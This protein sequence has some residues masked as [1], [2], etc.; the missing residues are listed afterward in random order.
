MLAFLGWRRRCLLLLLLLLLLLPAAVPLISLT[1]LPILPSPSP[2]FV[3]VPTSATTSSATASSS[4]SPTATSAAVHWTTVIGIVPPA[5]TLMRR[6]GVRSAVLPAGDHP[7]GDLGHPVRSRLVRCPGHHHLGRISAHLLRHVSGERCRTI[8]VGSPGELLWVLGLLW[9]WRRLLLLRTTLGLA[10]LGV[11]A[12]LLR[13]LA[14]VVLLVGIGSRWL[15]ALGW[16]RCRSLLRRGRTTVLLLLGRRR[17]RRSARTGHLH[18]LRHLSRMLLHRAAVG[19]GGSGVPAHG[20]GVLWVGQG[21]S[22]K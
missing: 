18:V 11:A 21:S 4:T 20:H 19:H 15:L 14:V 10:V 3:V 1:L 16:W 6:T 22:C 12:V 8:G 2:P 13:G 5:G 7:T 17:W 9:L